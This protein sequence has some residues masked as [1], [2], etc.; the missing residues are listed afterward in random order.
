MKTLLTRCL[1]LAVAVVT[2]AGCNK[3]VKKVTVNGS[4]T[5]KGQPL[6]SGIVQFVGSDGGAYSAASIQPGGNFIMTDVVPGDVK[7]AVQAAPGGSGSSSGGSDQ[8]A[9]KGAPVNL[10]DKFRNAETSEL[11]YTITPDTTELKIDIP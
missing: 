4:I 9:Q 6:Q 7:V 5:Y 10:P 8:P 2:V 11:K 3:S 1:V